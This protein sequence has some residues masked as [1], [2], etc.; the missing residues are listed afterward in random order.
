MKTDAEIQ[1]DVMAELKWE[2]SL[3]GNEIGVS[4][5]QGVVMLS[6][7]IDSYYKKVMAEKAAKRVAGVKAV[8]EE[9]TVKVPGSKTVT[10]VDIAQAAINAL[11][12]NSTVD[13]TK[14]KVQVENGEVTLEGEVEWNFQ[15]VSARKAVENLNGVCC[16]INN[17]RVKNKIV[18]KDVEQK[19]TQAFQRNANIDADKVKVEVLGDK[20]TLKGT[21]RSFAERQDAEKT[22]WAS[23][24]VMSV[25][26]KLVIDSGVLMY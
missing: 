23:P 15:K 1:K 21:V 19:I 17:I 16:I 24:G 11:K 25:E 22:A 26:N 2:P 20:V 6:G 3:N 14:I 9:I 13:E 4:V 10:D 18:A 8:A 12:W 5:K 7:V